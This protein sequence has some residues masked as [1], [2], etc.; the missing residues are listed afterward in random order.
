[1]SGGL[2]A[3]NLSLGGIKVLLCWV[4][5]ALILAIQLDSDAV[6]TWP[7]MT[8]SWI[9][10]PTGRVVFSGWIVFPKTKGW[11]EHHCQKILLNL[12][13][14]IRGK[15]YYFFHLT[16]KKK[17][18]LFC[19]EIKTKTQTHRMGTWANSSLHI[20]FLNNRGVG[21]NL[22]QWGQPSVLISNGFKLKINLRLTVTCI[23]H[24]C[25]LAG[26][27]SRNTSWLYISNQIIDWLTTETSIWLDAPD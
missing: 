24:Y 21:N 16:E 4:P 10:K 13:Q 19:E 17:L 25:S 27:Q 15:K 1:M 18:V 9:L 11:G 12:F 2:L 22:L 3:K 23:C 6:S 20:K 26:G 5:G 14:D 8:S 7:N